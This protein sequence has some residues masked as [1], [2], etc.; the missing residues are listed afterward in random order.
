M[1]IL[2]LCPSYS[3][4]KLYRDLALSLDRLNIEQLIYVPVRKDK[5]YNKSSNDELRNANFQYSKAVNDIDRLFYTHKINKILHDIK[6]KVDFKN[7]DLVHAHVLF[8]MGGIALKLKKEKNIDYI[9]AVRST[10]VN[11]FFKYMIHTRKIGVQI[12]KEAKKDSFY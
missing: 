11:V 5:E 2:H 1:N 6:N 7:I 4:S 10:D 8:S 9:V 3:D 12:M